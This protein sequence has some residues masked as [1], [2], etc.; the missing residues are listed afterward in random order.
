MNVRNAFLSVLLAALCLVAFACTQTPTVTLSP[1]RVW[2]QGHV[3]LR[4]SGFTPKHNVSS[5]LRKPDGKEYPV[6]AMFTDE[7]G[8]IKHDIDTIV[9]SPGTHELW[10]IDDATG[11]SSNIARFE[12]T[13]DPPPH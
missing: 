5:H 2:V 1:T 13:H 9:M 8:E 4:G 3:D 10:V 11:V 12:V 6:L 7:H